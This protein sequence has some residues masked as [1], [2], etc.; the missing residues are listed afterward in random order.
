EPD[1]VA[2]NR[3]RHYRPARRRHGAQAGGEISAGGAEHGHP[4]RQPLMPLARLRTT[5][6]HAGLVVWGGGSV[7]QLTWPRPTARMTWKEK[8]TERFCRGCTRLP[9]HDGRGSSWAL[10]QDE[11]ALRAAAE[12]YTQ[13]DRAGGQSLRRD[14]VA[15]S[16]TDD[17]FG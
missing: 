14:D 11:A 7:T 15:G 3:A 1:A 5:P 16:R 10:H 6:S 4:P 2:G 8:K 17:E 9:V 13:S 12:R